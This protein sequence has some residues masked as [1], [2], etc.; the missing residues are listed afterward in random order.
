MLEPYD[1]GK[2]GGAFLDYERSRFVRQNPT[3]RTLRDSRAI[4]KS[5]KR[6]VSD[7]APSRARMTTDGLP[8]PS[9]EVISVIVPAIAENGKRTKY[10]C[11]TDHVR[12]AS[13]LNG[14]TPGEVLLTVAIGSSDPGAE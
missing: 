11:A 3:D 6:K 10:N 5:P 8:P 13:S 1:G 9:C 7:L 2:H 12:A 14:S 4:P